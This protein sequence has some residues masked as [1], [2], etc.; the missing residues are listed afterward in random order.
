MKK[1]AKARRKVFNAQTER[2]KEKLITLPAAGMSL[3]KQINEPDLIKGAGPS[4]FS[5]ILCPSHPQ[6]FWQYPL[7][8]KNQFSTADESKWEV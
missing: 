3:E 6:C 5:N 8:Y 2:D 7:K 4:F 1:N